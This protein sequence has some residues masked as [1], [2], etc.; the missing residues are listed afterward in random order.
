[1]FPENIDYQPKQKIKTHQEEKLQEILQ[2]VNHNSTFYRELF[3]KHNIDI[4]SIKTLEDLQKIPFTEKDDLHQRNEDFICVDKTKIVDYIT[5]SG[6]LGDPITFALTNADLDRLSYNE[7][8]SFKVSDGKPED[9]Y[10]LMV[11]LDRRFMAG[12][13]YFLGIKKLG[14]GMVRVGNGMVELQWDTIQRIKPNALVAVPSFILKLIEYAEAKGIDYKN[15]SIEKAICIGE[16]L[17]NP[18]FTLNTLG[19]RI[20]D[21]WDIKLYSTYAS[22]EMGAAFA[23]CD[24]GVGGH[25]HPELLIV[26]FVDENNHPVKN[27]EPG[28]LVITTLDVEGMPLIRFKTGDVVQHFS[29]PCACGRNTMR[30]GP[31]IGRKKE[32]IKYKGTTL[33]PPALY[34][35][36]NEMEYVDNYVVEVSTNQIGTDDI[37]IRVATNGHTPENFEKLIKDHFRAKL[38]VAPTIM[39]QSGEEINKIKFPELK[40]KP[41]VFIDKRKK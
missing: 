30:L 18:D 3:K 23:D 32:M 2:Y 12:L 1:M 11:T 6:T 38:R 16:A 14:A 27:G 21:K 15:S 28:E 10:Q 17:R 26:E 5:T 36:L 25:H 4:S 8:K 33:Y 35:I 22:T 29:E 39:F 20:K 9:I 37:L 34:D 13:A 24:H 31:V 40:R 41:V 7:C 19:Q